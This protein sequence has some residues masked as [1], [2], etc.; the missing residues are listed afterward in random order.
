MP[1]CFKFCSLGCIFLR[2]FWVLSKISLDLWSQK[3]ARFCVCLSVFRKLIMSLI[4]YRY[5][6]HTEPNRNKI[7]TEAWW[8]K[9]KL[10]IS[11]YKSSN[12]R[13]EFI[14]YAVLCHVSTLSYFRDSNSRVVIK[15]C[16]DSLTHS[17]LHHVKEIL[18]LARDFLSWQNSQGLVVHTLE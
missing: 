17:P 1:L 3:L 9:P 6:S 14:Y 4:C 18:W 12:V 11:L 16:P 13:Q 10:K 5:V 15:Q 2:K 8:A 7:M